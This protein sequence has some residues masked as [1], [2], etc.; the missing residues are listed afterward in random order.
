M[1][2]P[3]PAIVCISDRF[4]QSWSHIHSSVRKIDVTAWLLCSVSLTPFLY[5]QKQQLTVACV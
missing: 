3:I 4:W 5:I 1:M 2:K